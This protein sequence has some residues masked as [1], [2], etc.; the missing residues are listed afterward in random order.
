MSKT[1]QKYPKAK[2]AGLSLKPKQKGKLEAFAQKV[3]AR[4]GE[5][6]T[7]SRIAQVVTDDLTYQDVLHLFTR[8]SKDEPVTATDTALEK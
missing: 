3:S 8:T 1:E 6:I 2:N 7:P 4:I 5:R